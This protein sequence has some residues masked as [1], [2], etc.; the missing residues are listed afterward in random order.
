[1]D[2][3]NLKIVLILAV[4]FAL[5]SLFGYF[6]LKLKL[7]SILGYLL[8]GYVIGP[9]SPGFTADIEVAEQLAEIGVVL[10]MFSVGLH[11]HWKDLLNVR[12][13]AIPGALG[14]TCVATLVGALLIRAMGWSWEAG[15]VFGLAIGVAST[16]V[17]VRVLTDH[18]LLHTPNGHISVGWL[19]VEDIITVFALLLL[20]VMESSIKGETL[21]FSIIFF[22]VA[23][24]VF[25]FLALILIMFTAGSKI[26]EY[27]LRKILSI[28]SEELFTIT[29]LGL[30][31]VIATGSTLLFGT[32]IALGAF[33]AGLVIGQTGA[34]HLITKTTTPLRD[35]FVVIFFLSVGMLFNPSGIFNQFW[36][37]L[38]V[39]GI[40]LVIKPLAAFL[41][42]R[43][44]KKPY[45]TA[46]I[47][48]FALA[49]IGEFSFIL[50]EEA[51]RMDILPDAAYDVIIACAMVSISI[52]PLFFRAFSKQNPLDKQSVKSEN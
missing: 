17:L 50:A 20:P 15:I 1:M 40:V 41:I 34:R 44:L 36:F 5:A 19:I 10:M 11:F 4:G 18:H 13:I 24:V 43:V 3:L 32:S 31:F 42:V 16:V 49:Q 6:S 39:L 26:V 21:S 22:D 48:A 23:L 46:F 37:F 45:S 8:A 7:S 51:S 25:K 28:H 35:V 2:A 33:V 30:T 29:V 47:V 14:Q 12:N 38:A 52:N 9:F 27:V